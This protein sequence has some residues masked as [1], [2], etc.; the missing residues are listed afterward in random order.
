MLA[1]RTPVHECV[2]VC[3]FCVFCLLKND[4]NTTFYLMKHTIVYSIGSYYGLTLVSIIRD[5][6]NSNMLCELLT[7]KQHRFH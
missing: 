5:V 2:C 7:W 3:F 6:S 4:L 1:S